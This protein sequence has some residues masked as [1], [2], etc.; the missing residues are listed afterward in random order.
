MSARQPRADIVSVRG[1][2]ISGG[3]RLQP[4]R[5]ARLC[6]R[7]GPRHEDMPNSETSVTP[8]L[9]E[10]R[11]RSTTIYTGPE[12]PDLGGNRLSG[13]CSRWSPR[14]SRRSWLVCGPTGTRRP[15]R[16][17]RSRGG[18]YHSGGPRSTQQCPREFPRQRSSWL[19]QGMHGRWRPDP[20]TLCIPHEIRWVCRRL[21]RIGM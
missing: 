2:F 8:L 15:C 13:W 7:A 1:C 20:D 21:R 5:R 3:R 16:P 11:V 18:W 17:R 9:V 10:K 4:A 19:Y 6:H 12:A 14:P